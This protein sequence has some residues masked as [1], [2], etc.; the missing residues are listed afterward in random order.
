MQAISK[1][2]FVTVPLAPGYRG[3]LLEGML[4]VLAQKSYLDVSV[5]DIVRRA[6]VSK[7]TFYE[8]FAD[9]EACFLEAY[10]ALSDELLGRVARAAAAGASPEQKLS[11][12]IE[13]YFTT[14]SDQRWFLRAFLS[15][16]HA[17]GPRALALRRKILQRFA[18][19]LRSKVE[20]VRAIQ[21]EV[22]ELSA[23]MATAIVGGIHELILF[24]LEQGRVDAL[25]QV[26]ATTYQLIHA[27]LGLEIAAPAAA[28]SRRARPGA[29]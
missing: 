7:R 1:G 15:E 26:G 12:A 19:L 2:L 10:A 29:K 11:L 23:E 22:R 18:Q 28:P 6:K 24:T 13:A 5:T 8:H 27:A 17:A 14:L 9:K 3:R 21:P 16:I 25:S 20:D 4:E